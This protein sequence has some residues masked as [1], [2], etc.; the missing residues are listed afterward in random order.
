MIY[1]F[2]HLKRYHASRSSERFP[3]NGYNRIKSID[4]FVYFVSYVDCDF[5]YKGKLYQIER[6]DMNNGKIK[7]IG[8]VYEKKKNIIK[9]WQRIN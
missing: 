9:E 6:Y 8:E 3:F 7:S 5:L 1:S 4:N 2:D